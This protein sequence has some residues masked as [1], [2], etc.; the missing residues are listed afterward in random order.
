VEGGAV[1][2]V[3]VLQEGP[4]AGGVAAGRLE[5]GRHLR[6]PPLLAVLVE[7]LRGHRPG[8][9]LPLLLL[10]PLP[11]LAFALLGLLLQQ[12]AAPLGL[13][14]LSLLLLL[15]LLAF[16]LPGLLLQ[17]AAP[18]RLC[19]VVWVAPPLLA[20]ERNRLFPFH[21]SIFSLNHKFDVDRAIIFHEP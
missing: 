15:P 20:V 12:E 19:R 4:E 6:G 14:A 18:L 2:A 17:Q 1:N 7:G 9:P 13:L 16:E 8:Q 10:L 21:C 3:P 5:C 11:L